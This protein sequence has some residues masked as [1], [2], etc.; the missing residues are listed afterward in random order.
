MLEQYHRTT[1]VSINGHTTVVTAS[2][3]KNNT[4]TVITRSLYQDK[5]VSAKGKST[6]FTPLE[7]LIY[8]HLK[9]ELILEQA[10]SPERRTHTN[11][12]GG[13][14]GEDKQH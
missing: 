11:K 2:S 7:L 13:E 6:G 10:S 9:K 1:E 8:N 4:G 3:H 12:T 14:E 5:Y